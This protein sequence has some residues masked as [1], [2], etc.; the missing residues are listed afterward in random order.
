MGYYVTLTQA[1]W[2]IP[3]ENLDAAYEAMCALNERDDL[4]TGGT[5]EGGK[6]TMKWFAWMDAKYPEKCK[7][8]REIL[9]QLGFE[10]SF[11]DEGLSINYYDNKTGAEQHFLRAIAPMSREHSYM[12]WRGEDDTYWRYEIIEGSLIEYEGKVTYGF[13]TSV[14][15]GKTFA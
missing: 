8:A 10:V 13:G 1:D 14:D 3:A 7:D 11:V 4:K 12:N 9:E 15:T 6:Q 5:W 2:I